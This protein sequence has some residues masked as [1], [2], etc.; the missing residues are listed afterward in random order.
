MRCPTCE[1]TFP[2]DIGF[3]PHDG[4]R[5]VSSETVAY[6]LDPL[7]GALLDGRFR[8]ETVIGAG[9]F[10]VVYRARQVNVDREVAVK[11]LTADASQNQE[12]VRRFENEA[13]I[14]SQ[15]RHP[16]TL[17]LVDFGRAPD[18]RLYIV[19]EFLTGLPLDKV[20]ATG[21]IDCLRTLRMMAQVCDSLT[22]AH[23][24]GIVHRDLKPGNI[25]L[26]RVGQQEVVKVLDFGIAKLTAQTTHTATGRIFGTPAYMSPEQ[27]RGDEI[28]ARSDLYSLGVVAYECLS[29]TPPFTGSNPMSILLKHL[30][31]P[32][33]PLGERAPPL[34][35]DPEV[36]AL[37]LAMLSKLADDRPSSASEVRA[38]IHDLEHRLGAR[39]ERATLVPRGAPVSV[40][41]PVAAGSLPPT[42]PAEAI[43]PAAPLP[44]SEVGFAATEAG[45][46]V[47]PLQVPPVSA[48]LAPSPVT[49]DVP[50]RPVW[51]V[52]AGL[53]AVLVAGS[54]FLA[55]RSPV[56]ANPETTAAVA[57][58]STERVAPSS[59][60]P[61]Q[62][63][64]A[65]VPTPPT[66]P[67]TTAPPTSPPT[68]PAS[69]LA[70]PSQPR[71][72]PASTVAVRPAPRPAVAAAP[73]AAPTQALRVIAP[74]ASQ[75]PPEPAPATK[76]PPARRPGFFETT[77]DGQ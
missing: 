23:E 35:L 40:A 4:A 16:N 68:A 39:P 30:Q 44:A 53:A 37:V 49:L 52:L 48:H 31:E 75:P 29:G 55:F 46:P 65:V 3:C 1:R 42:T 62:A 73:T 6:P 66:A 34:G 56:S 57:T 5:L 47:T 22:E 13:K 76:A 26:E 50:K 41:P 14:I 17:K 33:Q 2:E 15:L 54:L 60:V 38:S 18:G 7:I 36:D 12:I 9:G 71:S 69:A 24:Q 21:R 64:A 28:D 8:L 72:A 19:T 11:V 45:T 58:P 20:L 67:V 61:P 63:S 10:G 70:A 77:F 59:G 25:F 51:P 27:A 32:P 74:P 43:R